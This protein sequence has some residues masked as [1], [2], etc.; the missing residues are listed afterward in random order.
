MPDITL[1]IILQVVF[2]INPG[3]RYE[4]LKKLF[5]YLTRRRYY[6]LVL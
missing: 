6:S 5:E 1:Q 2:G 4:Q 3:E